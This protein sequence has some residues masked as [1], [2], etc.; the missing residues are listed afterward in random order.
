VRNNEQDI[1]LLYNNP[2]SFIEEHQKTIEFVV[3]KFVFTGFFAQ[4]ER[5]ELIQFVNE[6]LLSEKIRKMQQQYRPAYYVVT[7]LSKIVHNICL[8]YSRKKRSGN[9]EEITGDLDRLNL[10]DTEDITNKLLVDE[11]VQRLD[12]ILSLY[13]RQRI[14]VEIFLKILFGIGVERDEIRLLYPK[15]SD[16]SIEELTARCDPLSDLDKKTDKDLYTALTQFCNRYENK[17]NTA[18]A[19]RKYIQ[20]KMSEIIELLNSPPHRTSYDKETLK[21]LFQY[22]YKDF[23]F[24]RTT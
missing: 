13:H 19:L 9:R 8:E 7:Y 11:E 12:N 20:A 1:H 18:D 5:D 23:H 16:A 24:N 3:N 15:A 22:R 4:S 6:R 10:K 21:I 14:R 2:H 17:N